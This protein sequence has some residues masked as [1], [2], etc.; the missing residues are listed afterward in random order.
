MGMFDSIEIN[1]PN[2]KARIEFCTKVGDRKL[3][4]YT[5][6]NA[7]VELI[8]DM[9]G[10]IFICGNCDYWFTFVVEIKRKK[11]IVKSREIS[12]PDYGLFQ[13]EFPIMIWGR[14]VLPNKRWK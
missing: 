5:L 4:W 11:A 7:P 8:K 1:C 13:E 2:C 3:D 14:Y 10:E 6:D 9:E 12:K